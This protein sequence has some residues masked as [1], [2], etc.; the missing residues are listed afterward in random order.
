MSILANILL[1]AALSLPYTDIYIA[2]E[3]QISLIRN[4]TPSLQNLIVSKA[5]QYNVD[6]NKVMAIL[7]CESRFIPDAINTNT[8][9]TKDYS[10]WQINSIHKNRALELGYDI[11][12][13]EDNL[14]F[15]FILLSTEGDRHWNSSKKCWKG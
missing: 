12:K 7:N 14:E 5:K 13:P 15:G 11:L 1:F 9:G 2:P 6:E 4:E 8:N 3:P 10:Y